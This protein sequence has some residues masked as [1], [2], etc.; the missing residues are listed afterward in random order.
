MEKKL[1]TKEE[2]YVQA[3]CKKFIQNTCDELFCIR[4]YKIDELYNQSLL[5][6]QQR[7]P[8]KLR[9]DENR[10][11]EI[12]YTILKEYQQDILN[13]VNNGDNI[14]IYSSITGNGKTSWAIKFIQSYIQKIWASSDLTC[15]AL[16]INV[17]KFM[18]ELKLNIDIK[19]EY[20][21]HINAYAS[22]AD[23]VI[24]DDIATKAATEFEHEQLISIIDTRIDNTKSNIFTSNIPP[25]E[26][27][28]YLGARLTSRIVGLSKA[29]RFNGLDK[30]GCNA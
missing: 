2:C 17:P 14:Y 7:L 16:F 26:L 28:N 25:E 18:R 5:S 4:L 23:L 19:S 20:I 9:L 8:I 12:P 1:I 10:I 29:V 22:T 21:Q 6:Q 24:W 11:D 3:G 15:K 13:V 27:N 30:R